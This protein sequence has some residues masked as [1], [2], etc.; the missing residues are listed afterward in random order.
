MVEIPRPDIWPIW[1][2]LL[3]EFLLLLDDVHHRT[4]GWHHR[5]APR[6][7]IILSRM[8]SIGGWPNTPMAVP[9]SGTDLVTIIDQFFKDNLA[10]PLT[11]SDVTAHVGMSE[12]TLCRQFRDLTG[13][14]VMERLLNLRMDR[15]AT[16][17]VETDA[18]LAEVGMQVG[19]ADASYFCRR[20]RRHFD[21]TANFYR[22]GIRSLGDTG[23]KIATIREQART[24]QN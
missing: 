16:L 7:T 13:E 9:A 15:A 3:Q 8:L 19:I 20:F 1:P 22:K 11:L 17:L 14:T 18:S 5:I 24:R 21:K 23:G 6:I 4:P 12:R 10:R 2:D